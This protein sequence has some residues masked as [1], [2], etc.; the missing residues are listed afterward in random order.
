MEK[1]NKMN[2]GVARFVD[3]VNRIWINVFWKN[4]ATATLT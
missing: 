2:N 3:G 4:P 1:D